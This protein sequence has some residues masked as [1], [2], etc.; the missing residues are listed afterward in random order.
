MS[1]EKL[2][3]HGVLLSSVVNLLLLHVVI[4]KQMPSL[5]IVYIQ[6]VIDYSRNKDVIMTHKYRGHND[7]YVLF[8][9]IKAT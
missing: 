4:A 9:S 2:R 7:S 3:I 5:F 8:L 6:R 1:D